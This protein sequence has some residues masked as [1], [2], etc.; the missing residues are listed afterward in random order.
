MKMKGI[1]FLEWLGW[2]LFVMMILVWG[3]GSAQAVGEIGNTIDK[4]NITEYKDVLIPA[5]YRA[6]ERGEFICP[7]A[8]LPFD[9]KFTDKFLA[10][11]EKNTS[12]FDVNAE[13][14]LVEKSTGKMFKYNIY[15]LPFPHIDLKDPNVAVKIMWNFNFMKYRFIAVRGYTRVSWIN[16]KQGEERYMTGSETMLFFQGRPA[17]KELKNPDNYLA[18][19]LLNVKEPMSS[20]GVNNMSWDYFDG[21]EITQFAYIPV[22]RRVRQ[23]SGATRSDPYMG[24][25][26]WLD[27][28]YMWSGKNRTMTWKL[29]GERTILVPFSS[30]NKTTL[31]VLPD[32]SV[33]KHLVDVKCG[34]NTPGWKGAKWATTNVTWVPRKVYVI[35][36]MPKDP[37]YAWGLHVNYVDKETYTIWLKE[38]YDR[39][40]QFYTWVMSV[41]HLDETPDGRNT[42]GDWDAV[43]VICDRARH[44]SLNVRIPGKGDSMLFMPISR[45]GP[46]YFSMN[47]FLMLSK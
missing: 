22:I 1:R 7:T 44:A 38:V 30:L 20:R 27:L 12:K 25:D 33:H 36:Q 47:N 16:E 10:L 37:Y 19:E 35:E 24:S 26:I 11:S 29:V 40:G 3:A 2:S 18:F 31:K 42:V 21:R 13:G 45:L 43:N 23:T 41:Y 28:G 15:G 46:D 4:T 34:Y 39:S 5:L 9:Y 32:G 8:N 14:D 6:I 17:G